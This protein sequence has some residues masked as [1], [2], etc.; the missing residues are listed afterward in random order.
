MRSTDGGATWNA[1]ANVKDVICFGF[2]A[3][4]TP[5]G[6]PSIYIVGWV[7]NVYGVWQSNNNAQSW[8]QIGTFPNGSLDQI[9]TIS[10]DPNIYGQVYVGFMGSGY[11]YLP[12]APLGPTVT[13]VTESPA[14]GD[15][16]AGNTVTLTLNMSSAVTVA[17]GVPTLT[18]NDGG[19]ATY[20]SGSGTS[21]LVFSYTV[22]AG[23]DTAALA[24][25]TVNL[26]GATIQDSGG[27]AASLTLS[28][29]TQTGP[30]I[31]TTV[32]SV[33][34]VAASGTGITAGSGALGAGSAVTLTVNLSEAVTVAGGVPTLT[35][36]DGG[37]ATYVGGSGTNAL[38]FSYTV[39]SGQNTAD[40]AVT[41][42][43]LNGATVKDG[44]GNAANTAGAVTNPSGTL[45]I[46][47]TSP[48]LASITES[49]SS[50]R[51]KAGR[52]VTFTLNMSEAVTVAGGTPT[53]T[54]NSGGTA[55]YVSGS[56]TSALT[57]SYTVASSQNAASLS[58]TAVNLNGATVKDAAGNAA[59]FTLSGL[60]QAGAQ[61]DTVAP[62]VASVVA[63][64]TGITAGSGNLAVGNIVT[65]TV[66]LSE[67]VT[68]AGGTPTLTLNDGGVATYT[69]GSGTNALTFS[70]TVS[71]TD[72]AV[73]ALAVTQVNLPN[74]ATIL[75]PAGNSADL[76][77]ALASFTGLQFN[78]P[79]S[80]LGVVASNLTV[81][82]GQS[83]SASNLFVAQVPTGGAIT[84]YAF[85]DTG[86]GGGHFVVNGVAQGTNQ[87]I[88]VTAAQLAQVT[89]QPGSGADTLWVKVYDGTQWSSW[90]NAFT[91]TAPIDTGPV[92]TVSNI[93]ASLGQTF[94]GQ[95]LFTY[96]DPFGD[97]A[98]QYDVWN[99][100]TGGGHFVLNGVTLAANQH[101]IITAAQLSQLSYVSSGTDTL[102]VKA[103]DGTVWGAWSSGFTVTAPVNTGPVLTV[104]NITGSQ[105]QSFAAQGLFT[106]SDPMG[107]AAVKY[108]VWNSGTGG[109]HFVLNGVTLAANKDN[110]ITAAELSQLSYVAGSGTDTL[111]IKANDGSVWGAWSSGFTATGWV[112][113]GPVLTVSNITASHNQAFAGQSLF[114]YSDPIGAA[115]TQYDVWNSGTGG[116][117][118]VLN[119]VTLASNKDNII[120]AAQLSQLSY[121]A[122]SGTD[123]LWVK[124]N[125]G[126]VWGAW[127]NGFTVTAPVDT[128]PVLAPANSTTNSLQGQVFSVSSL[129]AYSDPFGDA[130]VKYD[131]WNS[132]TGGGHFALNGVTLASN[133]DNFITAAQLSQLS[134]VVGSGTD[135][136]WLKAND[137]TVWGAWSS[138]FTM[139]NS[140]TTIATGGTLELASAYS[141]TLS[142]AGATGTL[143]I[144]DSSSFNGTIAGQLGLGHFI[145]LVD[146]T[147]GSNATVA[148]SGNN[149]PG[150]LTVSDGTHTVHIALLGNYTLAN[151]TVSSDG[152]GGT[153]LVDPPISGGQAEDPM[154]SAI[155]HQVALLSQYM[156]SE[157]SSSG[158]VSDRSSTLSPSETIGVLSQLACSTLG[159]R[160]A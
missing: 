63:S 47:T 133:Q 78:P 45:K 140:S 61:I 20:V 34:S 151:F 82:H 109:G 129:F 101:N 132:G 13:G 89:Y 16:G 154:D 99:L 139:S 113:T 107:A 80:T 46:D 135:T 50:G 127:S 98:T 119:G 7:N 3:A 43:N 58:A 97:A 103:N 53:L 83:L 156:S 108:D 100:G 116:G 68:I 86:A 95:N 84:K 8:T 71:S 110:F 102:W 157:F 148:Y 106:Y 57:F 123:T 22:G 33:A 125:D 52:T 122:G 93:T 26:N 115:A 76:S 66:N 153:M 1:I 48:A 56:G 64:G 6:Y 29:L 35:L 138:G 55:T 37:V 15:F 121:V 118:F 67:A 42:F 30:Q 131:V 72:K 54:L 74:G 18:L 49:P 143:K 40:L 69:G 65:L 128:G 25:T 12:A 11:A 126:S 152:H 112:N 24:A 145:D 21:A 141:G 120:T 19:T 159:Q 62:T 4:A 36:N 158:F 27:L 44:A 114:T 146:I 73:S 111:W 105:G 88:D 87:E 144:D 149:S 104:S 160:S 136:L 134:Y 14:T 39:G 32:P 5:G 17:G 124:A 2:G 70:Y 137:G 28:G 9:K 96:S 31:D 10:G 81:A 90:S 23:Q 155:N 41:A 130:A 150:T 94:A 60:A 85:W 75:D 51:L 91:V 117:H 142:F 79:S 77:G 92:L 38:T 147:A 59:S